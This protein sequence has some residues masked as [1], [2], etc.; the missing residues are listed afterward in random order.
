[1]EIQFVDVYLKQRDAK[2]CHMIV[3]Q[4]TI[5]C[6]YNISYCYQCYRFEILIGDTVLA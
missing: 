1:M 5:L 4:L 3:L 6:V 2:G